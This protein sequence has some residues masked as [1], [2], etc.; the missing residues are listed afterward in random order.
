MKDGDVL[1]LENTRFHAGE[2]KND[3]AFAK[4]A[5]EARRR[6]R[7]RRLL[8]GAPRA[9]LDRGARPPAAGLCRPRHAGRARCAREG[10]RG[11]GAPARRG[12]R[13]RQGLDQDRS[14]REPRRRG[15]TPS[16]SAAA[17]RTPSCSAI[18][19][20][21]GRSL[22][23]KDLAATARRIMDRARETELRHH[24]A[25]RRRR[26]RASSRRARRTTPTASTRSRPTA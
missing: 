12:R 11:A 20:G 17:W 25:G 8:G 4:A 1:L 21:V 13:R 18:D 14:S 24:P 7:Q 3:P 23:E 16:S 2:E 15:S 5:G 26:R 9:C 19:I 22:A 6:L 10:P